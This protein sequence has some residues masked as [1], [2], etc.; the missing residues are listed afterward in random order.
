MPFFGLNSKHV[1]KR[2]PSTD[3]PSETYQAD[4]LNYVGKILILLRNRNI[5]LILCEKCQEDEIITINFEADNHQGVMYS[6]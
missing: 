6:Y 3:Y 2:T 5:I 4:L 1:M